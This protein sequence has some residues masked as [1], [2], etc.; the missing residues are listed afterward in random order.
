MVC[1]TW[2]LRSLST[3]CHWCDSLDGINECMITT[4]MFLLFILYVLIFQYIIGG[5]WQSARPVCLVP[6]SKT[7]WILWTYSEWQWHLVLLVCMRVSGKAINQFILTFVYNFVQVTDGSYR[8]R[9]EKKIMLLLNLKFF[10][11]IS[12]SFTIALALYLVYRLIRHK[13]HILVW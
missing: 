4:M 12:F 13:F 3:F 10:L 5:K 1:K 6:V 8:N 11:F 7:G 9:F 2:H